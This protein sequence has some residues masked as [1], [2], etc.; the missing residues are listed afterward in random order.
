MQGSRA[1]SKTRRAAGIGFGP[2]LAA[3]W[4]IHN[5]REVFLGPFRSNVV[6]V[7]GL[8]VPALERRR[9]AL[10]LRL[11]LMIVLLSLLL[12]AIPWSLVNAEP[13]EIYALFLGLILLSV[14]GLLAN[15]RGWTTLAAGVFVAGAFAAT[16]WY[17]AGS[18]GGSQGAI[19]S[20]AELVVFLL[21]AGL[22]L[23]SGLLWIS[24]LIAATLTA[25]GLLFFPFAI[26]P[27]VEPGGG[28]DIGLVNQLI[29]YQVLTA[30]LTQIYASSSRASLVAAVRAYEQEHELAMLKDQFLIDANHELRTPIMALNSNVQLLAKL[31]KQATDEDRERLLGR[32][33]GAAAHLQQVLRNV[34]DVG[35]LAAGAPR[36]K[37]APVDLGAVLY[38]TV[39]T[40]HA[41]GV[42]TPGS[43]ERGTRA[44]TVEMQVAPGLVVQADVASLRQIL[45][46]LVANAVKYSAPGTPLVISATRVSTQRVSTQQAIP[47]G[48][49]ERAAPDMARYV[50]VGVKD[51]GLGVPPA[52]AH[53]LFQRFVRLPRDI[54]GPVRGT[55]VGLYLTRTLVE[56]MGGR[57]WVESTGV[58]GAGSTFYFILPAVQQPLQANG[59]TTAAAMVRL[60]A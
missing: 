15:R 1:E 41:E 39:A 14:L 19:V 51:H 10:I 11:I 57:I 59:T 29:T 9:R 32:A 8:T 30:L 45:L 52:E 7:R 43:A 56:A 53:T 46:N 36:L 12:I 33:V 13:P 49:P 37:L 16:V 24:T 6:M 50:R 34:L 17:A 2:R 38:D 23:P 4:A 60:D 28:G 48:R 21:V 54:A 58:P 55:G 35:A 26:H 5:I 40:F 20:Y 42:G 25:G 44:R 3:R 47:H 27:A 31:G 22:T 18:D